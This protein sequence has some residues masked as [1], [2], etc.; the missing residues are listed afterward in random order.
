MPRSI[1]T[2]SKP[3]PTIRLSHLLNKIK[4][5]NPKIDPLIGGLTNNSCQVKTNDLFIACRGTKV[6]AHFFIAEALAKGAAAV[7][8]ERQLPKKI[9]ANNLFPKV[10]IIV[11]PQLK[12]H[13]SYLAAEFYNHPAKKMIM[14]GV[15][16]TNGKTTITKCL[17][18]ALTMLKIPCGAIG[19]FGI[20]FLNYYQSTLNTTP[21]PIWLQQQLA[22]LQTLG[23]KAVAME[24]SSH[25]LIQKRTAAINFDL[26]IFTNLTRDHLDTHRTMANYAKAKKQLFL[27]HQPAIAI[28]N[29][30]DQYGLKLIKE[31]KLVTKN[32]TIYTY[33]TR[34]SP[35]KTLPSITAQ[36]INATFP[37]TSFEI[38]G[39]WGTH[40]ITS[41]LIGKFNIS[42]LL[43]VY[44]ALNV[45]ELKE[46]SVSE[47]IKSLE[48]LTPIKGRMEFIKKTNRPLVVIDYAHTP[49]ALEQVLINLKDYCSGKLWC[50]FGCGG[51]RDATKRPLMG[52]IAEKYSN[53]LIITNDNP[54]AEDPK[55][56]INEIKTGLK[57][58]SAALIKPSRKKAIIHV[59]DH[60]QLKDIIL[61]AGKG[62]ENY[63]LINNKRFAF[64]DR[65]VVLEQLNRD[66]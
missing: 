30:D 11:V 8:C 38:V 14:I 4:L 44:I 62:H 12:E 46:K 26:A 42:N 3:S 64:S 2:H 6:D 5:V 61:I 33:G 57:K 24:V 1:K 50:I 59:L 56:I 10:P 48:K 49:D 52:K 40:K 17:A 41:K 7:L 22:K 54:R 60:A 35:I 37:K 23:A 45:I 31:L 27:N 34:P 15:T 58:P 36:K 65:E 43:A 28:I 55:Q 29:S 20:D 19:T 21:D 63:Q 39:P 18:N 25:G 16:G 66:L 13:L 53:Y 32:T 9:T 47:I 51:N